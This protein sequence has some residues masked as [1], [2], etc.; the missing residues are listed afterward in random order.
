MK[1][2]TGNFGLI[3][4]TD[5]YAGNFERELCAYL[6]GETGYE[7]PT[8]ED[9]IVKNE[10]TVNFDN[11]DQVPDEHGTYRPVTITPNSNKIYNDVCIWFE[12]T[13]TAKQIDFIKNRVNGFSKFRS[14]HHIWSRFYKDSKPINI[15][16]IEVKEF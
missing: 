11:I 8:G 7:D 10:I 6:T 1:E 16:N 13:P 5:Q 4:S 14:N 3:I 15:F 12:T 2:A 9:F